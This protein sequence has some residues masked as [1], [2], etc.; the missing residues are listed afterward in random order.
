MLRLRTAIYP[1]LCV[2]FVPACYL[3]V[4]HLVKPTFQFF[5]LRR[6]AYKTVLRP[7]AE[8]AVLLLFP[9][10]AKAGGRSCWQVK[11]CLTS[12]KETSQN[13]DINAK[14]TSVSA[15]R[16]RLHHIC[17]VIQPPLWVRILRLL[18]TLLC[19][20]AG[21]YCRHRARVQ[22]VRWR[23]CAAVHRSDGQGRNCRGACRRRHARIELRVRARIDL[24]YLNLI[25]FFA[26]PVPSLWTTAV[27]YR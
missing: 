1:L 4:S 17:L 20:L 12:L 9:P 18:L 22:D 13:G 6:G 14:N 7:S 27:R 25:C 21:F 15:S 3:V 26:A 8:I 11:H 24:S 10:G 5:C 19:A 2:S 23:G 16:V